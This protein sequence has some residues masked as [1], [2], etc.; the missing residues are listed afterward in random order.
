MRGSRRHRT[1]THSG[2]CS[3]LRAPLTVVVTMTVVGAAYNARENK[4]Q[5]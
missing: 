4:Q 1:F 2:I 5:I 3:T